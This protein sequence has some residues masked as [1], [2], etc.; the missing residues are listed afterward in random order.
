MTGHDTT[1][2]AIHQMLR[3]KLRL[4]VPADAAQRHALVTLALIV[5]IAAF[6]VSTIRPGHTWGD[7]YALYALHAKSLI[8]GNGYVQTEYIHNPLYADIG[9]KAYPPILPITLAVVYKWVG[10]DLTVMKIVVCAFFFS[11]L[12]ILYLFYRTQLPWPYSSG[13]ILLFG[14]NPVF[15]GFKEEIYADFPFVFFVWTTL[16][17]LKKHYDDSEEQ[18]YAPGTPYAIVVGICMYLAYGTRTIGIVLPASLALFELLRFK[19]LSGFAATVL[20]TVGS[21]VALQ[22]A[23]L[24][25][26]SGG[27]LSLLTEQRSKAIAEIVLE[28]IVV[29]LKDIPTYWDNGYSKPA[30]VALFMIV[31]LLATVGFL[32]RVKDGI[33]IQE[34]FLFLYLC[35][36]AAFPYP[37][38]RYVYPVI[39]IYFFYAYRGALE[40]GGFSAG[41]WRHVP[42]A[43]TALIVVS[44][45]FKYAAVDYGPI[46]EGIEKKESKELFQHLIVNSQANDVIIFRKPRALALLTGRR[47]SIYPKPSHH[48]D[49]S[50][51]EKAWTYFRD[52]HARYIVIGATAWVR[53]PVRMEDIEWERHFVER[54]KDRCEQVFSNADFQVYALKYPSKDCNLC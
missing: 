18:Q 43:L 6:Y 11:T 2:G 12:Y 53:N 50:L 29:Y 23:L 40:V 54:Y 27:Y 13:L 10:F 34:V 17:G 41:R 5:I 16:Y 22:A 49:A 35:V 15:W 48:D 25:D 38:H 19:K 33:T 3:E 44:Y 14:L 24:S 36:L 47:S 31:S 28:N 1:E 32:R 51:D 8:E 21:L 30:K 42:L 52:I 7:D 26:G 9:P 4:D 37:T 46:R 20:L 45:S 39:P